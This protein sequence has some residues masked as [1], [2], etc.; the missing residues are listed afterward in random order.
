[1]SIPLAYAAVVLIWSTTPL[2]IKWSSQDVG[3]L[4]GITSRTLLGVVAGMTIALL[5]GIRLPWHAAAC[6]TYLAAGLGLFLA[7]LSVYWSSQY[8]PSGWVSVLFGLAPIITGIMARIWLGEQALIP[9]RIA[10]MLLGVAGLAIMLLSAHSLGAA[11]PLGIAGM[12]FSVTAYSA[13]AVAVKRIGADIPA[14]AT[15]IGALTVALPLLLGVYWISGNPLPDAVPLRTALAIVYLG[16]I[17]SVLG[18]ALYYYVLRHMD[19]TRVALI[20]LVTPV[21]ALLLG[22]TLNG[23]PVQAEV[24]AGTSAILS[25]LVL[26]QFGQDLIGRLRRLLVSLS[27]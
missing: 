5:F 14:L 18:F 27:D 11:A 26:F 12:L 23:E 2:A 20:T 4:F 17:G 19:A 8:I 9:A 24:W 6:R 3:F 13:S 15:T 25:G 16:V 22:N 1:M 10:G 7:L 21:I